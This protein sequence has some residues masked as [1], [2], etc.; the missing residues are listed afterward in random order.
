MSQLLTLRFHPVEPKR[1]LP[2]YEG[3]SIEMKK[4]NK[5]KRKRTIVKFNESK[6]MVKMIAF[7]Y[8][9]KNTLDLHWQILIIEL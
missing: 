4:T 3:L 7:S 6:A 9:V 2:Y 8:L 5:A 1:Y